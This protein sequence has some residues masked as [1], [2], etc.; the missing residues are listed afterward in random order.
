M[1]EDKAREFFDRVLKNNES[2]LDL[3]I[4]DGE[5]AG[6]SFQQMLEEARELKN[7][8]W[9]KIQSHIDEMDDRELWSHFAMF[10]GNDDDLAVGM[11][12]GSEK[13]RDHV[14]SILFATYL[15]EMMR[16]LEQ[17]IL[18][19]EQRKNAGPVCDRPHTFSEAFKAL[20]DEREVAIKAEDYE[21]A[22]HC[23]LKL[24]R[25]SALAKS[26]SDEKQQT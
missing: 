25:W 18:D 22:Q 19:R 5:K 14:K 6:V 15:T 7:T 20:L 2:P 12:I 11:L 9:G 4:E 26:K 21:T 8:V 13:G 1:D 17:K 24:N 10:R 3:T 16:R 23:T